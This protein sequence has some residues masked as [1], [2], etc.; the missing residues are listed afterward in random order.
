MLSDLPEFTLLAGA[1]ANT[2]L[3]PRGSLKAGQPPFPGLHSRISGEA[4]PTVGA[5]R[6][7]GFTVQ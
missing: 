3:T 1:G 5:P 4:L 2:N 7:T 6:R